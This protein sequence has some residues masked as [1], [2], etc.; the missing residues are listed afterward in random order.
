VV[1]ANPRTIVVVNAGAPVLLPWSDDVSAILA[2]WFPGQ[3]FGDALADMLSGDA[4]PGGRLPTTWPADE[5]GIPVRDVT[6]H[7]GRLAYT[8]GIHIGY[9]AWLRAGARPAY[10]FG[11][12]LGYTTWSVESVS[13]PASVAPGAD[14]DVTVSLRNTGQ[15]GGKGVVQLYLERVSPS[16]VDRPS[17]WLAGFASLRTDAGGNASTTIRL[18]GRRLAH[19]DGEWVVE[20]G[21]YR[22]VAALDVAAPGES[23]ELSVL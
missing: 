6:P 8:E 12:G 13:A 17:R 21:T 14:I 2:V 11:H 1:A 19:W 9:R 23:A 4:E 16:A 22:V 18:P 10:P 7:D 5:D 15:R 3:E 20:P